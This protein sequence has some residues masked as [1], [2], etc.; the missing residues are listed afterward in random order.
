[1]DGRIKIFVVGPRGFPNVQGG[2][3]RFSENFYPRLVQRGYDVTSFAFNRFRQTKMWNGVKFVYLPIPNIKSLERPLYDLLSALYCIFMRPNIVHVH[4]I[5][6]GLFIFLMKLGGLRIIARYN[7]RDY[8]HGTWNRFAKTILK[9][10][11]RQFLMT[12]YIITNNRS[13]L[14]HLKTLGRKD[15]MAY[16]PNGIDMN[17]SIA[18]IHLR[19]Q[20]IDPLL[21]GKRFVLCVGRITVEKNLDTLI[22][23]FTALER[24]DL[25]LVIVGRAAHN[26]PYADQLK[27]SIPRG[28]VLFVGERSRE[29]VY[30]LYSK[31]ALFVM[32]SLY[33][34]MPNAVIE[35]MS[36]N[37]KMLLS[38][39]PAHE[40][41]ELQDEIYFTATDS[42]QLQRLMK[43]N[44]QTDVRPDYRDK[45]KSYDWAHI[46]S[47][48]IAIQEQIIKKQKHA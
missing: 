26:D 12:D 47:Q 46:V 39:I 27:K 24:E 10:S 32:P 25:Y 4:S 5:A 22:A 14:E 48:V 33:E 31:C 43:E 9:V 6:S 42:S 1:M 28:K 30:F 20:E 19:I 38:R 7:S 11:E 44:L 17:T 29:E 36:F 13:Y 15:R 3:E 8:L 2:I 35:A 37:C 45:L 41:L 16:V 23:A 21:E 18:P 34:G 40:Q